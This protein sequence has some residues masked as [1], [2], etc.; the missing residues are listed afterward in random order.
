MEGLGTD[1]CMIFD[2][3]G[4]V[5]VTVFPTFSN[6][7]FCTFSS[8]SSSSSSCLLLDTSL[9][10]ILISF[11]F[12]LNLLSHFLRACSNSSSNSESS[13]PTSYNFCICF[14]NHGR[15]SIT[16]DKHCF[17]TCPLRVF[18]QAFCTASLLSIRSN[19]NSARSSP[20][21]FFPF[22]PPFS[23]L[24]S[25]YSRTYPAYS[26]ANSTA[27]NSATLL[28]D[29]AACSILSEEKNETPTFSSFSDFNDRTLCV[30]AL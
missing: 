25:T 18:L 13:R 15:S 9:L 28:A 4:V 20:S 3:V 12:S 11:V 22:F 23:P 7:I 14:T 1:S 8:S 26:L 21:I 16:H 2:A 17:T 19:S 5:F 30:R 10:L 6:G 29:P 24:K 27:S